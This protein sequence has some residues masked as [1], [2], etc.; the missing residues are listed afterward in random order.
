MLTGLE[1][2]CREKRQKH[3]GLS[4]GGKDI[5]VYV[6]L[7][8]S[9]IIQIASFSPCSYSPILPS[10]HFYPAEVSPATTVMTLSRVIFCTIG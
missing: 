6:I 8:L 10:S 2:K 7:I 4:K 5:P 1:V 9:A 3:E